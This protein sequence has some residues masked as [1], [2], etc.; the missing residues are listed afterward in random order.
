MW[1]NKAFKRTASLIEQNF[2]EL[3]AYKPAYLESEQD[4][5]E[6][7]K[8]IR[9]GYSTGSAYQR[10]QQDNDT[11]RQAILDLESQLAVAQRNATTDIHGMPVRTNEQSDKIIR[12]LQSQ[13]AE[14]NGMRVA[15]GAI[16]VEPTVLTQAEA[17]TRNLQSAYNA[18]GVTSIGCLVD[19]INE[20]KTTKPDL[21]GGE[22]DRLRGVNEQQR[23]EMYALEAELRALKS[24]AEVVERQRDAL[25]NG[26]ETWS[27][28]GRVGTTDID[29]GGTIAGEAKDPKEPMSPRSYMGQFAATRREE[30]A[31]RYGST[32]GIHD[33][34]RSILRHMENLS[35]A[36]LA[37]VTS[38]RQCFEAMEQRMKG[39]RPEQRASQQ[40][41]DDAVDMLVIL[42]LD[43]EQ[44]K[45]KI[46]A[47]LAT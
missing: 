40:A 2:P 29:C 28:K 41:I 33:D 43:R 13:L 26:R 30:Q 9:S 32:E 21:D 4:I 12:D 35:E 1:K 38:N 39:Q 16:A 25:L 18:A 3:R 15:P 11:M 5:M 42:G 36:N 7:V 10:L 14:A 34:V 31:A 17:A 27:I 24:A 6:R 47:M 44:A 46:A 37:M 19:W 20:R 22:L 8:E 45:A 23:G